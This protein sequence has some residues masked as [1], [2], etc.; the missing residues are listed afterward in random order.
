M[1]RHVTIRYPDG[2]QYEVEPEKFDLIE[3]GFEA[4][5]WADT[6]EAFNLRQ[7]RHE[8]KPDEDEAKERQELVAAT[9]ADP[10]APVPVDTRSQDEIDR[11]EAA[12]RAR[13]RDEARAQQTDASSQPADKAKS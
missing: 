11:D 6:G 9:Q 5:A 13:K 4:L 2:R 3:K 7:W 1:A 8:H 12:E 10:N